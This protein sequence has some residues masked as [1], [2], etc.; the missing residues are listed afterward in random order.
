MPRKLGYTFYPKDWQTDMKVFNLSMDQRFVYRELIDRAM[1]GDNKVKIESSNWARLWAVS[2]SI[3]DRI[4][5]DLHSMG[6]L[7]YLGSKDY[8][9]IPSCEKRLSSKRNGSNGGK[10]TAKSTAKSTANDTP[11][12][13]KNKKEKYKGK[14]IP[15]TLIEVK[16]YFKEKGYKEQTAIKAFEYYESGNWRDSKGDK[17]K[18]WKQ[19]MQG[20]WFK[21]ENKIVK[22]TSNNAHLFQS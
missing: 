2:A 16:D 10:A 9:T 21:E 6:L 17:V 14:F 18:S 13:K 19:K 8:V 22:Q 3:I 7:K 11:K 1:M 4:V 5:L 12:E 20:V 15:P